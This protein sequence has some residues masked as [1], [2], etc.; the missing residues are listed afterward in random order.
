MLPV[1]DWGRT[2]ATGIPGAGWVVTKKVLE[3]AMAPVPPTF[4]IGTA[5]AFAERPEIFLLY[6]G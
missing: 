4:V 6:L 5:P 1:A 2:L 3:L